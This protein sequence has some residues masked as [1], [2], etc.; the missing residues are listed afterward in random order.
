MKTHKIIN[1]FEKHPRPWRVKICKWAREWM[2]EGIIDA[3]GANIVINDLEAYPPDLRTA[4][5]IC[6]AINKF[7][8]YK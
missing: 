5:L 2:F 4:A 7:K 8:D 1:V 3:R 6:E